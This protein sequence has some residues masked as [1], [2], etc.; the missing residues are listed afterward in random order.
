MA[1]PRAGKSKQEQK[2]NLGR[3]LQQ[4]DQSI[5]A[6][7]EDAVQNG[8]QEKR[9]ETLR[10]V[11]D[12]FLHDGERLSEDQIKVFD[13]VLCLL[14]AR[15]ESRARAELS[16]RLAPIDYAPFEVIQHLARDDEIEV[17]GSVLTHS[18]RLRTSDL[19]EIASTRGQDHLFAI[20]GRKDLPE[21]VTD[22]IVDR[23]ERNVIRKLANNASARFSD[24]GFSSIVARADADDELTEI[25][26]LRIDLP[27]KFL[28]NLLRRATDAVRARLAAVAP[29]ELQEEITQILNTIASAAG[30]DTIPTRDFSRAEALTKLLME[31]NELDD[32][33]IIKFAGAKK[34]DE[35]AASLAVLNNVSTDMMARLLEGPRSDLILIPCKS[36]GLDWPAVETI[37]SSRPIKPPISEE[38]LKLAWSDYGRLSTETAR[39]TLRFWQVHNRLEK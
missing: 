6:E 33:A 38:T 20:S 9:V 19:V 7:L 12:L 17:A 29:P 1:L 5:I 37:L 23:G 32:A 3:I 14:I 24:A 22:V 39:R 26:G 36:A 30:E 8:S 18:N 27:L 16:K 34:F 25:L 10:Q 31:H 15:V 11:T 21:A 35:V 28:R 4:L 2:R 13:D